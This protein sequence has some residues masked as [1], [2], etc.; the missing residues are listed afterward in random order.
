MRLREETRKGGGSGCFDEGTPDQTRS[1]PT[2]PMDATPATRPKSENIA[3]KLPTI[4][5]ATPR[6]LLLRRTR[7]VISIQPIRRAPTTTAPPK[8]SEVG[9]RWNSVKAG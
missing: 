1:A 8:I 5:A 9:S 7:Y 4:I 2:R 3:N 6:S